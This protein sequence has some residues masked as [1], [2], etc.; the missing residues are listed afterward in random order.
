MLEFDLEKFADEI[1]AEAKNIRTAKQAYS[2]SMKVHHKAFALFFDAPETSEQL[3]KLADFIWS[4]GDEL[5]D[6]R[7]AEFLKEWEAVRASMEQTHAPQWELDGL[8]RDR[9]RMEAIYNCREL[10]RR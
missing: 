7:H 3:D 2:L 4:H 10:H 9:I 1:I 5:W 8:E 6:Q